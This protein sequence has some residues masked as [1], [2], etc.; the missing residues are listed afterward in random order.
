VK[1][2][3]IGA[4]AVTSSKVKNGSLRASDL[5]AAALPLEPIGRSATGSGLCDDNNHTGVDCVTLPFALPSAGRVFVSATGDA[6]AA[7]LDDLTGP[8]SANDFP[9]RATGDC[10]VRLDGAETG[11]FQHYGIFNFGTS[12]VSMAVVT[13]VVPAG[14]HSFVLHCS[15]SDGDITWSDLTLSAVRLG[16]S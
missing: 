12:H 4:G 2:S 9:D 14:P 7:A 13:D 6:S 5:G 1:Q 10:R 3:D 16:A 15:E 8:G 11:L